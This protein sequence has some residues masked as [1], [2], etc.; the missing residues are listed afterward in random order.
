[1]THSLLGSQPTGWRTFCSNAFGSHSPSKNRQGFVK[2]PAAVSE[3]GS[4][5]F[6]SPL[7]LPSR[8]TGEAPLAGLV[9]QTPS[10]T[11]KGKRPA[12]DS[13]KGRGLGEEQ[14][15]VACW[16]C[17]FSPDQRSYPPARVRSRSIKLTEK[18]LRKESRGEISCLAVRCGPEKRATLHS[19]T[20]AC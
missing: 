13:T 5:K 16:V 9:T 7:A 12:G 15:R 3:S 11:L 1:M 17:L 20:G 10:R 6:R 18:R 2:D 19:P 14:K 8:D 4:A